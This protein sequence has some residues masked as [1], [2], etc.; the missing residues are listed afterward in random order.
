MWPNVTLGEA[1]GFGIFALLAPQIYSTEL[2]HAALSRF[3]DDYAHLPW[4]QA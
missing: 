1:V 3:L 2:S 4:I